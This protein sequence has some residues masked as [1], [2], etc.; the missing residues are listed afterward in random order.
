MGGRRAVWEGTRT[1][2]GR[3][4]WTRPVWW[5]GRSKEVCG[6]QL[7]RGMVRVG[8]EWGERFPRGVWLWSTGMGAVI[9]AQSPLPF[10]MS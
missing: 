5:H 8:S 3:G 7:A 6:R 2:V 4:A 1:G 9:T 10:N